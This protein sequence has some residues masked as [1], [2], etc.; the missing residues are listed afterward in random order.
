[1][2]PTNPWEVSCMHEL[3]SKRESKNVSMFEKRQN[4][5][6]RWKPASSSTE[7]T[8]DHS[9]HDVGTLHNNDDDSELA[10]RYAVSDK[11]NNSKFQSNHET[12]DEFEPSWDFNIVVS[13]A[14]DDEKYLR[15]DYDGREKRVFSRTST[16]KIRKRRNSGQQGDFLACSDYTSLL[17]DTEEGKRASDNHHLQSRLR[18]LKHRMP[19]LVISR[20]ELSSIENESNSFLL[21]I[22]FLT[23]RLMS[24]R[25]LHL[26]GCD[27]GRSLI[28]YYRDE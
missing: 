19:Q 24:R 22:I 26:L 18:T 10:D 3:K 9:A 2:R 4:D 16:T 11:E 12:I 17:P 1:M 8:S 25:Q 13:E 28:L 6:F 14:P 5:Y 7:R 15:Y 23:Y 27:H 20:D 21:F